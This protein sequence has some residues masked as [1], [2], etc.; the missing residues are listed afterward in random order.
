MT[1]EKSPLEEWRFSR[2]REDSPWWP[3]EDNRGARQSLLAVKEKQ[4]HCGP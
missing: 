3:A 1:T 2:A 4:A